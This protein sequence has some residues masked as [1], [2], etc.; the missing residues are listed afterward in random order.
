MRVH[1]SLT[2]DRVIA[3]VEDTM[4]NVGFCTKCGVE[5][6]GCEPDMRRGWCEHCESRSVYG[7][8]ELMFTIG[9]AS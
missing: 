7:A 9:F 2:A 5:H 3:G 4:G 6:D 1:A 8:E